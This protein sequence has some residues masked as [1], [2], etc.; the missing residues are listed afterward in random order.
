MMDNY[1]DFF[2]GDFY[3]DGLFQKKIK[4]DASTDEIL[5]WI[6]LRQNSD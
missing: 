6:N 2:I 3:W 5:E 1:D 4:P